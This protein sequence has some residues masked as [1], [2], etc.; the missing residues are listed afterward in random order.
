MNP[1]IEAELALLRQHYAQV[2]YLLLDAVHWF[3]VES[4][5]T[6]DGWSPQEISVVFSVTEG[7]PS[8]KP[9]GFFVP[10]ELD[11][12]GEPPDGPAQN[13]SVFDGDWRFLSWDVEDWSGTANMHS[14]SNLWNWVR[15]FSCR[16]R[17][18]I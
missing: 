13:P 5:R 8:A 3:K 10:I 6:P 7:Y 2:D 11:L 14:G 12:N 17:E 15:S 16:L 4:L 9:Y 1:R 18:G